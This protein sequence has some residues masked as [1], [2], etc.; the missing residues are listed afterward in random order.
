M[1]VPS[2]IRLLALHGL[3]LKGIAEPAVVADTMGA[4]TEQVAAE[5]ERLAD[6]DLVTYRYGRISGYQLTAEGRALAGRLVAEELDTTGTRAA[7]EDAYRRFQE[8]NGRLLGVC[9]AWQLRD[10]DGQ[11]T[12]NDHTD[13]AYDAAVRRRLADLHQE[14]E[15]V[16]DRLGAALLR[17]RGHQKRLRAAV[18]RVGAGDDDYFTTPM[19]PSYH[20]TWFEL[21]EDLLATLGTERTTARPGGAGTCNERSR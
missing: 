18:E 14:A 2:S 21:H 4:D 12:L 17:F 16:L 19:F 8:V 5:L 20:S 3:R 7:I 1:S 9:T 13:P 6:A 10:T 15:P 11:R